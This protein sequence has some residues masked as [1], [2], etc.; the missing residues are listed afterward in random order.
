MLE[1]GFIRL[2]VFGGCSVHLGYH[3]YTSY[4]KEILTQMT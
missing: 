4:C 1:W 3:V 2:N